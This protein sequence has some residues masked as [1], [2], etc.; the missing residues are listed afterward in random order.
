M[1]GGFILT[2][3]VVFS[4]L[5]VLLTTNLIENAYPLRVRIHARDDLKKESDLLI[6]QLRAIDNKRLVRGPLTILQHEQLRNIY[7]A[8]YEVMG[9]C[10]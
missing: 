8:V 9:M 7:R 3:R 4:T 10:L 1:G 2:K 5:A 6:D